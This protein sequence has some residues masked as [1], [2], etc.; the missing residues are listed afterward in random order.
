MVRL[1][2]IPLN[3]FA[4]GSSNMALKVEGE[5]RLATVTVCGDMEFGDEEY[6]DRLVGIDVELDRE[7][8]H[9]LPKVDGELACDIVRKYN[10]EPVLRY[11]CRR[12][13]DHVTHIDISASSLVCGNIR[14]RTKRTFLRAPNRPLQLAENRSGAHTSKHLEH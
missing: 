1:C 3:A 12:P 11:V 7:V 14:P 9:A 4:V 10:T 2:P 8:L 5:D 13:K 6:D